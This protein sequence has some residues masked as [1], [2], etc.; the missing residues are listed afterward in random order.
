MS[1]S[2]LVDHGLDT[3]SGERM[4]SLVKSLFPLTRSITGDGVR[5]T[6]AAVADIIPLS[7]REVPSGTEV[8]DW[9]VPDEW[10]LREA[11]IEQVD[12]TR[13]VDAAESNLHVV[14]YSIPFEGG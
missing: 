7:V 14:S 2:G 9:V 5:A 4:Y 8:C 13:I 12:G 3:R 11:Y 6:L 10:S 1:I